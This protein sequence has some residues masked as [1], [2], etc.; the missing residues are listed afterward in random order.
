MILAGQLEKSVEHIEY[1]S[2]NLGATMEKMRKRNDT[3]PPQLCGLG[4]TDANN[5]NGS[6][7]KRLRCRSA[8]LNY[9]VKYVTK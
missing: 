2:S 5:G 4:H 7:W 6:L 9:I 8:P 1:V 3:P